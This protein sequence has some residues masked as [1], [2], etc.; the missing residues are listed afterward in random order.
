MYML[1]RTQAVMILFN[2]DLSAKKRSKNF[3]NKKLTLTINYSSGLGNL[4]LRILHRIE[5]TVDITTFANFEEGFYEGKNQR[6]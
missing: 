4:S 1:A 2:R 6:S 3:I 5:Q